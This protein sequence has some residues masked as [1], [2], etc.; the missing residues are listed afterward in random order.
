MPVRDLILIIDFGSQYTQLIA[1]KVR[2]LGVYSEIKSCWSSADELL[3]EQPRGIILSG[4][5]NSVYDPGAPSI[6]CKI[7]E[8]GVPILGVCYGQQLMAHLL[9]GKVTPSSEREYGSAKLEIKIPNTFFQGVSP[10][11]TVWMSHGDL[12][13]EPPTGFVALATTANSPY[14]AFAHPQKKLFGIQFHP[15]VA[16]TAEG[17]QMLH[18]FVFA[19]CGCTANWSPEN[20]IESAMQKIREQVGGSHVLCALSGGVDSAVTATLIQRAIGGRLHCVFVDHGLMRK[21][22]AQQIRTTFTGLFSDGFIAVD[23]SSLFLEKL[24]GVVD[25]EAKRKIIGEQYIRVFEAEARKIP[26]VRFLAQGTLYPDVI[27]SYSPRGGPSVTIKT[28]HNVGGL[29]EKMHLELLE[30]LRELFK[31]EVRQ[32]GRVLGMPESILARHPFPGPGLAVR[33]LGEITTERLELLREADAIFISELR[34]SGWYD[35]V[36]QAFAVLLPVQSVGVMGDSRT[37]EMTVALRAVNSVD[38]MTADWSKLPHEL[39][40][41]V[42]SRI[43]NEVRGINRVV[44]DISSKPPST[45]EW[46]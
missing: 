38:G 33:I 31:D 10:S 18:N 29:P 13:A 3:R 23:A 39:L 30:P 24:R 46:E 42:S 8:S 41:H 11:T 37:Y 40:S 32:C 28:H 36:W 20:F 19:V 35:R 9:G 44:Y 4:G 2:E 5:P 34:Q 15:E 45:I 14:A 12:V 16:H 1:R 22:E 25:P 26:G 7:F 43:T 27:E 6:E 17:R 21:N